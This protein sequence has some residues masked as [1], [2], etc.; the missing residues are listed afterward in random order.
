MAAAIPAIHYHGPQGWRQATWVGPLTRPAVLETGNAAETI[1]N[2]GRSRGVG[3]TCL[4]SG[5]GAVAALPC[6][7][8]GSWPGGTC[9]SPR[10]A[11]A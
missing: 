9:A 11:P 2:A 7:R 10:P 5:H 1:E 6:G 8:R 3:A 4:A